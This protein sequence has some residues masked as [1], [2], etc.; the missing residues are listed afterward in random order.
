MNS[1][2]EIVEACSFEKEVFGATKPLRMFCESST[3]KLQ[4]FVKCSSTVC[5]PSSL[6]AEILVAKLGICVQ[7]NV[8]QSVLVTASSEF[9]RMV[10]TISLPIAD[11]VLNSV[12]PMFGSVWAGEG[13]RLC[14]KATQFGRNMAQDALAIWVLDELLLNPDR[15]ETT[16]NCLTDGRKIIAIDHE[17]SLNIYGL[18]SLFPE[19]WKGE[20]RPNENHLFRQIVMGQSDGLSKLR[21]DWAKLRVEMFDDV[22]QFTSLN[23]PHSG[24]NSDRRNYLRELF[25]NIDGAFANLE[26]SITT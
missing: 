7:T 12:Q 22:F 18:G 15:C 4:V 13:F 26:R 11:R 21:A 23:W 6:E 14:N 9:V 20:W 10:N 16:P 19:P 2:L 3:G 17:K 5:P 8:A 1:P 24:A 25:A